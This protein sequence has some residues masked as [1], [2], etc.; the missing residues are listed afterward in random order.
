ME[1]KKSRIYRAITEGNIPAMKKAIKNYLGD[2]LADFNEI[3]SPALGTPLQYAASTQHTNVVRTLLTDYR[4][5]P[6]IGKTLISALPEGVPIDNLHLLLEFG[7]NPNSF[8]LE[9][10]SSAY[11]CRSPL[12]YTGEVEKAK[13]LIEYGADVNIPCLSEEAMARTG[14]SQEF[15]DLIRREKQWLARRDAVM[16]YEGTPYAD[17]HISQF[18]FDPWMFREFNT[19]NQIQ[20]PK[21]GK[22][23]RKS[24][25]TKR[26]TAKR[27]GRHTAR[28]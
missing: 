4:A 7:A 11:P 21:G 12:Y 28:K 16:F 2:D 13:L 23:T 24:R 22:K 18:L 1:E 9:S 10:V 20:H 8:Y 19:Y 27:R 26:K 14:K 17:D 3:S 5:N 25:R 6:R 15:K